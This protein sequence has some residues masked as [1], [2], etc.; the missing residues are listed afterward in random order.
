MPALE[1]GVT[2]DPIARVRP[3]TGLVTVSGTVECNLDTTVDL[4]AF[5]TQRSG[6]LLVQGGDFEQIECTAPST[7][8]S[9]DIMGS[10]GRFVAGRAT[11]EA[12]VFACGD[13]NSNFG[14]ATG[15]IKLRR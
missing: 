4:D 6:R 9:F 1:V 2:I 5:L 14:S 3:K 7:T 12:S 15:T 10:N 8:W 13:L 11:L